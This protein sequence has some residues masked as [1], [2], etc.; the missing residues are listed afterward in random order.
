MTERKRI[1]HPRRVRH[2]W[3]VLIALLLLVG[4]AVPI[5]SHSVPSWEAEIFHAI[6]DLPGVLYPVLFVVM[7]LGNFVAI[8]VIAFV[9]WAITRRR[10]IAIDLALS[11]AAAWLVAR[12]LKEVIHRGRPANLLSHVVV[13][14]DP[15]HGFGYISGH[16]AVAAALATIAATYFGPRITAVAV[17]LATIVGL[18]RIYVGAHLPLDVA[19]GAAVGWAVGS[20]VHFLVLPEVAGDV[21]ADRATA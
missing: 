1:L 19:G 7:Q 2:G 6:N 3:R 5:E 4:T 9:T 18:S 11:G 13:R 15:A 10:R 14:G 21:E 8:P 20:L 16:T 12:V 17:A